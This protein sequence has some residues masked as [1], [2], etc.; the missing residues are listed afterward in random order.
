MIKIFDNIFDLK[1]Q[2][3][4]DL[5]DFYGKNSKPFSL[6]QHINNKPKR[7]FI[8]LNTDA[9][10]LINFSN[11]TIHIMTNIIKCFFSDYVNRINNINLDTK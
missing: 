10:N 6:F 1:P 2:N 11:S 8:K 9:H 3:I 5:E 7:F 4:V